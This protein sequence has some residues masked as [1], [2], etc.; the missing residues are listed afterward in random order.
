M[1]SLLADILSETLEDKRQWDDIFKVLKKMTFDWES[2]IQHNCPSEHEGEF[3][4]FLDK[5]KWKEFI[6]ARLSLEE[7]LKRVLHVEMK[8]C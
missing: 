7:I 8:A 1:C 3:K 4:T 6:T 5:Q 2:Y